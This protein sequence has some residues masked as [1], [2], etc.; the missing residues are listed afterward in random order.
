ML[1][2]V[3]LTI[4]NLLRCQRLE[5]EA[6]G[7]VG[8]SSFGG[9]T[10]GA[11]VTAGTRSSSEKASGAEKDTSSAVKLSWEEQKKANAERRKIERE[12]QNLEEQIEAAEAKKA[13]LENQM[14]NPAVYSDGVKSREVQ[15]KINDISLELEKLNSAW[16]EAAEKLD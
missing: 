1:L 14:A 9:G 11:S 15:K 7:T 3:L 8:A 2:I 6:A 4:T 10:A 12:V 13:E 5:D 16:E